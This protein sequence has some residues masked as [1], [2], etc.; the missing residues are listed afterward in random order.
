MDFIADV[1]PDD[2]PLTTLFGTTEASNTIHEW[3]EDYQSRPTSVSGAVEGSDAVFSDLTNPSRRTN[4]TQ[5]IRETYR[6]SDTVRDVDVAGM[7]DMLDYQ[8][9]KAAKAWK[10]QLEYSVVRATIASGDSGVARQMA[11]IEATI[12]SHYTTRNSGT[13]LSETELNA[14]VY[15]VANDVGMDQVWDM[16]VLPLQLRQKVSTFTAGSTKF[17]DASDKRLTRPVAVYESDFNVLRVFAHKDVHSAAATPGP[18]ILGLREDKWKLAYQRRPERTELAKTGSAS[19][20]MIEGEVTI[21]F[22]AER[23]NARRSGYAVT[24]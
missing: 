18:T 24:G 9:T 3:T 14:M 1:S 22:L 2:N 23:A 8:A 17:V 21:E 11:G 12:T 7:S 10:N 19:K 13:S 15:D 16:L 5:I 20:G 6:V 4:I